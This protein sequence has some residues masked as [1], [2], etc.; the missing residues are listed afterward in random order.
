MKT[1]RCKSNKCAASII[2]AETLNGR[3]MPIDEET[4]AEGSWVLQDEERPVPT[5]I[6]VPREERAGR[7]DLHE[8]H[9]GTCADSESFRK[10]R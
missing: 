4:S 3:R 6:F 10:E 1:A 7:D 8:S 9:W 2:W 5:A